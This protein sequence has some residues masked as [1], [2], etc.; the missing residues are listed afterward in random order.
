MASTERHTA[1]AAVGRAG[2]IGT[3]CSSSAQAAAL[4][5]VTHVCSSS[6][7]KARHPAIAA[8]PVHRLL[9]TLVQRVLARSRE[10]PALDGLPK[11]PG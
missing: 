9:R 2:A 5:D 7:G 8:D 4:A 1:Q 6:A 11:A 3:R 10:L